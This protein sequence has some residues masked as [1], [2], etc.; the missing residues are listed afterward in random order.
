[1]VSPFLICRRVYPTKRCPSVTA[2]PLGLSAAPL[3]ARSRRRSTG[4]P[5]RSNTGSVFRSEEA[6]QTPLASYDWR[7]VRTFDRAQRRVTRR[8][9][10]AQPTF[11]GQLLCRSQPGRLHCQV[12]SGPP[13]F[14]VATATVEM[15]R[16]LRRALPTP[17]LVHRFANTGPFGK[18]LRSAGLLLPGGVE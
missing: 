9:N 10:A 3:A 11:G 14:E 1:M 12:I 7:L 8:D 18:G 5:I 6:I 4:H 13:P 15:L 17:L 2:R 16:G